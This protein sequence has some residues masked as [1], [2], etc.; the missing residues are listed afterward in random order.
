MRSGGLQLVLSSDP[1]LFVKTEQNDDGEPVLSPLSGF[2]CPVP[3]GGEAAGPAP[4]RSG[5]QLGGT[6]NGG[7]SESSARGQSYRDARLRY[8]SFSFPPPPILPSLPR[9]SGTSHTRSRPLPCRRCRGSGGQ[10]RGAL[11]LGR[12]R[13]A[14]APAPPPPSSGRE[15]RRRRRLGVTFP[16]PSSLPGGTAS[17][18]GS[19]AKPGL[20]R[21]RRARRLRD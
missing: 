18:S 12:A 16:A 19:R 15:P 2:S 9:C 7:G 11:G 14:A 8:F 1:R 6:G 13:S 21:P 20:T 3:R 4:S 10:H 17:Q 5:P